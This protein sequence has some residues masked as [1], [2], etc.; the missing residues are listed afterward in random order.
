MY[1]FQFGRTQKKEIEQQAFLNGVGVEIGPWTLSYLSQKKE[2]SR[3]A[4][5]LTIT[6]RVG[7]GEPLT[8]QLGEGESYS[9][10]GQTSISVL[11]VSLNRQRETRIRNIGAAVKLLVRWADGYEQGWHYLNTPMLHTHFGQAPIKV[12]VES[13]SPQQSM[14]VR[15]QRTQTT[16]PWL[17]LGFI[18]LL[19]SYGYGLLV[20]FTSAQDPIVS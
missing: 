2:V 8:V 20:H 5:N 12:Q 6:P 16:L 9:P 1:Q 7:S 15:I 11:S 13:F 19:L 18:F 10:D 17:W 3:L 14:N 4:A